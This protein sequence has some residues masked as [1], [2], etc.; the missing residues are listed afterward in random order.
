MAFRIELADFGG[1]YED[2][3]EQ[4]E[5]VPRRP[6]LVSSIASCDRAPPLPSSSRHAAVR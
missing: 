5:R 4:E 1:F 2:E 3:Q 6:V